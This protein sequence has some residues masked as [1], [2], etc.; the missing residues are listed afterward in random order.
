MRTALFTALLMGR[1]FAFV[2]LACGAPQGPCGPATCN[3]CCD[4][5]GKCVAGTADLGCGRSG[6][7]CD[8]CPASRFCKDSVCFPRCTNVNCAGCCDEGMCK[9]GD[10]AASCGKSGASCTACGALGACISG[11]CGGTGGS[12]GGTGGSSGGTGGSSG[13]AAGGA[14]SGFRVF[15][16]ANNVVPDFGGVMNGDRVCNAAAQ[17]A[18][19]GG[20]FIAWLST[21]DAGARSR[22]PAG[23]N[24]S[25]R[26]TGDGGV[27]FIDVGQLTQTPAAPL[28]RDE[29]GTLVA[30]T[31]WTGTSLGGQASGQSCSNWASTNANGTFGSV[32]SSVEWTQSGLPTLCT[33]ARRLYCFQ[34]Q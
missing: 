6:S 34:V 30:G 23:I 28:N 20:T 32:A 18:G 15:A 27:V 16:T 31:A 17:D 29:R 4:S 3:G 13:G 25:W 5:A 21:S 22:F 10:S 26:L 1:L 2:L 24:A 14:A 11:V 7:T 8:I 33:V 9:A 12:G 19:V